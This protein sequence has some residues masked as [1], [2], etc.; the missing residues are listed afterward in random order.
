[1]EDEER[2]E[3]RL[4]PKIRKHF[5]KRGSKNYRESTRKKEYKK[6]TDEI[7]QTRTFLGNERRVVII[8]AFIVWSFFFCFFFLQ[9]PRSPE[10]NHR[11]GFELGRLCGSIV[12]GFVR[13]IRVWLDFSLCSYQVW[14][15]FN[16]FDRVYPNIIGFN[17]VFSSIF[18]GFDWK[19]CGVTGFYRVSLDF[20]R[21]YSAWFSLSGLIGFFSVRPCFT[22]SGSGF[23]GFNRVYSD[24]SGF[25]R[26]WF[27]FCW[28]WWGMV[29][30]YRVLPSF[31]W[32]YSSLDSLIIFG[33]WLILFLHSIDSYR[34]FFLPSL[35]GFPCW[36]GLDPNV[37]GSLL[38]RVWR[39]LNRIFRNVSSAKWRQ[40]VTG[41]RRV[42]FGESPRYSAADIDI[43]FCF[44]HFRMS[45]SAFLFSPPVSTCRVSSGTLQVS[46]RGCPS[47]L[48]R[49]NAE[50][51][52]SSSSS[53]SS[54]SCS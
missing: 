24:I 23:N 52:S 11:N 17:W 50:E 19:S 30:C 34:V 41:G 4:G 27:D 36:I 47:T 43:S 16:G 6:N 3:D 42:S 40:E 7:N 25:S 15:G 26:F 32:F 35:L 45:W 5:K 44:V 48:G 12:P 38:K 18:C 10:P 9:R 20:T 39:D 49:R 8:F 33:C 2:G 22:K 21:T 53:S 14:V 28:V 31:T 13:F 1:M 46:I 29:W 37:V 51:A 54:S